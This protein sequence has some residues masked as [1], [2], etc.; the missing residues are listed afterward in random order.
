MVYS[1][2]YSLAI[3]E[4]E[5]LV[6]PLQMANFAATVANRGYYYTPHL[7]KGIGDTGEPLPDR[8]E[9]VQRWNEWIKAEYEERH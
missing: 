5:N 1:N 6:V 8:L 9:V 3:G 7:I 2:I 4:G